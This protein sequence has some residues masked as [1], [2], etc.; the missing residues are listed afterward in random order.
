VT[1]DRVVEVVSGVLIRDGRVWLA[2][3]HP[4][5]VPE[6]SEAW[7]LPGGKVEAGETP[8]EALRREWR[9]EADADVT[10]GALLS[11]RTHETPG[12]P[13][14]YRVRT[15]LVSCEGNL[16]LTSAGGQ[17][18]AWW[19]IRE[20]P[21]R[22]LPSTDHAFEDAPPVVVVGEVNPYGADPKYA[23]YD[24]PAGSAGGRLRRLVFGLCRT[25]YRRW[26]RRFNLCTGAWG[27][28]KARHTVGQ[29]WGRCGPDETIVLL[30]RK[31]A[32]AFG[33]GHLAPFTRQ[34]VVQVDGG[35]L[36]RYVILP[37]PSGRCRTWNE[38]DAVERARA[39]LRQVRPDVPW[40]ELCDA[41]AG[42]AS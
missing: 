37:H 33:L 39:L 40:G 36:L 11:S 7:C 34:D 12:Y 2:Q 25:S 6:W 27:P 14:P 30:G 17:A 31:V 18:A 22:R 13:H 16:Q 10:V 42:G 23:L 26:T 4:S 28:A 29:I 3:R 20:L 41:E 19:L 5:A 21:E 35:N 9:E 8:Q 38:P 15:Y 1:P 32:G 24:E